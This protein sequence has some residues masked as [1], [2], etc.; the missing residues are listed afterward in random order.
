MMSEALP[1]HDPVVE[2]SEC[3]GTWP[4]YTMCGAC[5]IESL[6]DLVEE[7]CVAG[8][9]LHLLAISWGNPGTASG[10][11]ATCMRIWRRS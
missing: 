5:Y 10:E 7:L 8:T 6:S 11:G 1:T 9:Y 4:D 3:I 2:V